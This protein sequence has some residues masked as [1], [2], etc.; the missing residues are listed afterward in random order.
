[1]EKRI[2]ITE[3][4][5]RAYQRIQELRNDANNATEF[6]QFYNKLPVLEKIT[7]E[8]E[9]KK[10]LTSPLNYVDEAIINQSGVKFG[11]VRPVPGQVAAL[12]GIPYGMILERVRGLRIPPN[13]LHL[14]LF[15]G[16]TG[17]LFLPDDAEERVRDEAKI[18]LS[19]PDL[20]EEYN[21]VNKLCE[22]LNAYLERYGYGSTDLNAIPS[23]TG[24][25][26]VSKGRGYKLIP[27]VELIKRLLRKE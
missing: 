8:E 15:D 11:K 25:K 9:A 7:T 23:Y 21:N 16:D 19:D 5:E 14:Y 4:T 20:V 6:I 24:L 1:M 17:R 22:D 2:L 12:F 13:M 27:N 18:Y 3:N 26:C 10:L